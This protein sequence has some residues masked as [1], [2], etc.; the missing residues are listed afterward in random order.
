MGIPEGGE[1]D[2][3]AREIYEIRITEIFPR[4]MSDTK[5]YIKEAQRTPSRMNAYD[6]QGQP[7]KMTSHRLEGNICTKTCPIKVC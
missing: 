3:G 5:P 7:S 2:K 4:L 1:K 6:R